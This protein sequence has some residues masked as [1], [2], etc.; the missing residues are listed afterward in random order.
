ML[1][2]LLHE[3]Q[4]REDKRP[5]IEHI[6]RSVKI[7]L[8]ETLESH[9]MCDPDNLIALILH[10][11]IE[12]NKIGLDA[13]VAWNFDPDTI[14]DVL[15]MSEPSPTVRSQVASLKEDRPDLYKKIQASGILDIYTKID[16]PPEE[17]VWS[18]SD[19][20]SLTPLMRGKLK[21]LWYDY[22]SEKYN[23]QTTNVEQEKVYGEFIFL[24]MIA[25]MQ[26]EV[27]RIKATERRDNMQDI[28]GLLNPRK[29]WSAEKT[30][31]TT[32]DVYIPKSTE[33]WLQRLSGQLISDRNRERARFVAR[34][35][36]VGPSGMPLLQSE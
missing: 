29:V 27:F 10:D 20:P 23:T 33:L 7:Y 36:I 18:L 25:R 21:A 5:Y 16:M 1:A 11:C 34:W 14:I 12:D 30:M 32:L 3:W 31:R 35:L 8:D 26:K 13:M 4:K 15:W 6:D 22:F 2:E 9:E 28:E 19:D 17:F 24:Y